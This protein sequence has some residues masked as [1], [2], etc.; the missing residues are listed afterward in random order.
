MTTFFSRTTFQKT[1]RTIVSGGENV[2]PTEIEQALHGHSSV[3]MCA[4]VGV[5]D[6]KWGEVGLACVTLRSGTAATEAELLAFLRERLA[7]Y[8]VPKS[9]RFF[10]TLPMSAAG[11]ILKRELQAMVE[12]G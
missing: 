8:K 11:K 2:Y 6:A 4:V 7:S 10:D 9:V 12:A 3:A 5:P 1:V